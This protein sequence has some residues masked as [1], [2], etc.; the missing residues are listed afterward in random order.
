M[1]KKMYTGITLGPIFDTINLTSSPVALW[2]SSY[3]FSML[4]A[5]VCRLLTENGIAEED[6]VTPFFKA[7]EP[8]LNKNNGIGL[9]HDRIIFASGNYNIADFAEIRKKATKEVAD[10][11]GI[12]SE[13]LEKY[14]MISAADFEAEN[15]IAESGVIL[16]C[17]EL[18]KPYV[19]KEVSN[20]ILALFSGDKYSK[21][22]GLRKTALVSSLKDFQLKKSDDSFKSLEEIVTTGE[23]FKKYKYYAIVRSDGDNMSKIIATLSDDMQIRDFSKTCLTYCLELS[24]KVKEFDGITI[25]SGGDDLLAILPCESRS[26]LTPLHFAGEANKIFRKNFEG[27]NVPASLSLGITMVYYK[28][29]L[30]EALDNSAD[31][32]FNIAKKDEKN[33][34]AMRLQKHAGQSAGLIISNDALGEFLD[35]LSLVISVSTPAE[36]GDRIFLSAIHKLSLF[37][38][39]FNSTDGKEQIYNLFKNVFDAAEHEENSFLH[40]KLPGFFQKLKEETSIKAISDNGVIMQNPALALCHILRTLKFFTEGGDEQ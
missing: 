24:D 28:Y 19:A 4:S 32:L 27:Y 25:Y 20:P 37:E 17:L 3:L 36:G 9:F 30:Y 14:V 40:E 12:D 7:D 11:F 2:A 1:G 35:L 18:S 23:G 10:A 5:T 15:P 13:Y 34:I 6:I 31:L 29:P 8:M 39:A 16:D 21:N 26:G 38:K 33:R 22:S